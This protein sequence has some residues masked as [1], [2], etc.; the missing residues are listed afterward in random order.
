MVSAPGGFT[1][2]G[3]SSPI[4]VS[5][6][7][8][9]TAYTFTVTATNVVGTSTASSA[10]NSVTPKAVP[11]APTGVSAAA[12]NGQAE[13]SFTAPSND[14]GS[15]ITGYTVTSSPGGFTGTGSVS[16]ITVSGL[17][18]GTTYTFTVTATNAE[19]TSIASSASSGV[20]P[21]TLPDAP[22]A[23][24]AT[25]GDTE[26]TI[27]FTAPT[28]NGGS[29]IT[30]Y[31]VT[32]S[33]GGLTGT[34]SSSPITVTGLTNGT[35]YTF[36]V[37]ATNTAGVSAASE[38]SNS[39]TPK[40][41][42]IA[43][44]ATISDVATS[45]FAISLDQDI[46]DISP[47]SFILKD[48]NEE[49]VPV[50]MVTSDTVATYNVWTRLAEGAT[51]SLSLAEEGY[52][53]SN[54]VELTVP[55]VE[56]TEI[57]A[58]IDWVSH[59]AFQ[60]T[61]ATDIGHLYSNE[62]I[63]KNE[64]GV[65]VVVSGVTKKVDGFTYIVQAALTGDQTYAYQI[66]T[67]DNKAASGS[68]YAANIMTISTQATS[69]TTSGFTV[70]LSAPLTG[71]TKA[72]FALTDLSSNTNIDIS[73]VTTGNQGGSYQISTSI[74]SGKTYALTI[75][76]E[77]YTV[78]DTNIMIPTLVNV[79]AFAIWGAG[80]AYAG[81]SPSVPGLDISNFKITNENGDDIPLTDAYFDSTPGRGFYLLT[82]PRTNGLIYTLK[83][84]KPGYD[85]GADKS[86]NSGN[87][88]INNIFNASKTGFTLNLT[89]VRTI[90]TADFV[91]KNAAGTV[92]PITS[93][94]MRDSGANY[95][96]S[97][98]MPSGNYTI[99][100]TS[101]PGKT[102]PLIR[103]PIE[104]ALTVDQVEKSSFTVHLSSPFPGLKNTD[105]Y[106]RTGGGYRNPTS[107]STTDNGLTYQVAIA[108]GLPAATYSVKFEGRISSTSEDFNSGAGA[109]IVIPEDVDVKNAVLSNVTKNG[110]SIQFSHAVPGL[111]PQHLKLTDSS[112]VEL[113]N[114][115]LA[116]SDG[117][118]NYTVSAALENG[119]DYRAV[120]QKDY[121]AFDASNEI[122]VNYWIEAAV[123]EVTSNG[124]R[125]ALN[126]ALPNLDGSNII[127]KDAAGNEIYEALATTDNGASYTANVGNVDY[128]GWGKS[129]T[130]SLDKAG[131]SLTPINLTTPFVVTVTSFSA[132]QVAVS[133]NSP[134]PGL[135]ASK[136]K[137]IN[138]AGQSVPISAVNSTDGG[139]T[140]AIEA[141]MPAGKAYWITY[142]PG[143]EY[144]VYDPVRIAVA[145]T[146]T[147]LV[148]HSTLKGFMIQF[149]EEI[150]GL[151]AKDLA[152]RNQSGVKLPFDQ[153]TLTKVDGMATYEVAYN[154]VIPETYTVEL[155]ADPYGTYQDKYAMAALSYVIP[156]PVKIS[157][158]SATNNRMVL[159][160]NQSLHLV[161]S[162]FALTDSEGQEVDFTVSETADSVYEF[163]TTA[164]EPT[165]YLLTVKYPGYDFGSALT[166]A[167]HIQA[168]TFMFNQTQKGMTIR[169]TP[170]IPDMEISHFT[171]TDELGDPVDIDAVTTTDFGKS[172]RV[173]AAL[174]SGH[175]YTVTMARPNYTFAPIA[176]FSLIANGA[177]INNVGKN[178]FK[179]NLF[180]THTFGYVDIRVLNEDGEKQA[181]QGLSS[182]DSG[183]TYD[184][185]LPLAPGV[186][187]TVQV[188][189]LNITSASQGNDYGED[190]P[191][192]VLA[193]TPSF[194]GIVDHKIIMKLVPAL[195]DLR[196]S[197][198]KLSA[199][200]DEI[201]IVDAVTEDGGATYA[202]TATFREGNVYRIIPSKDGYDFGDKMALPVPYTVLQTVFDIGAKEVKLALNPPLAGLDASHFI[203]KDSSGNR[204]TYLS[205]STDDFGATYTIAADF[206][207]GETYSI[208]LQ[209]SGY[210]FGLDSS[211][212]IPATIV[213]TILSI[214]TS[215]V[216]VGFKPAVT[217]MTAA[218]FSL[219]NGVAIDSVATTDGGATYTVSASLSE[220][221]TYSL[222]LARSGY[223]FD[224][225]APS[226]HVDVPTAATASDYI[227]SG[228][229]L[230]V[231]PALP[232]LV[233]A[234]LTL[235]DEQGNSV[236]ISSISSSDGGA[237]YTV[238]AAL[239]LGRTYS[240][241]IAKAGY[242]FG[243]SSAFLVPIPVAKSVE[244]ISEHGLVL[245]LSPAVAQ[246]TLNELSLRDSSGAYVAIHS[247]TTADNGASYK[248]EAALN[249]D[250]SYELDAGKAGYSFGA[251][252]SV[253]VSETIEMSIGS[254]EDTYFVVKF[255][256]PVPR[257]NGNY[258]QVHDDAGNT[259]SFPNPNDVFDQSGASFTGSSFEVKLHLNAGT[260]YTLEIN[261]PEHPFGAP[262]EVIKPIAV[263]PTVTKPMWNSFLLTLGISTLDLS[264]ADI[265]LFTSDGEEVTGLLL[266]P[267]DSAG[268]YTIRGNIAE[269]N[270]YTLKLH[271][272]GYD[273]GGDISFHVPI[274]VKVLISNQDTNGF[275]ITLSPSV[276]DLAVSLKLNG[277]SVNVTS[278]VT[279][280]E[281]YTY[282]VRTDLGANTIHQLALSK[283]GYDFGDPQSVSNAATLPVI[284][285]AVT[286][287]IGS[288]IYLNF[289][290]AF[291]SL[292][293]TAIFSV[294]SNNSWLH[295]ISARLN[296]TDK[297]QIIITL[298]PYTLLGPAD[299][300]SV[301]Y[302]GKNTAK[303]VNGTYLAAFADV[304]VR[305]GA[306]ALGYATTQAR[307]DGVKPA[308]KLKDEFHLNALDAGTTM[309]LAGF[310]A[311]NYGRSIANVYG[312]DSAGMAQ[313]LFDM[314]ADGL[315][316][317]K[318]Q[319]RQIGPENLANLIHAGY[320]PVQFIPALRALNYQSNMIAEALQQAD[321][322]YYDITSIL[323]NSLLDPAGKTVVTLRSIRVGLSEIVS[324]IG[325]VY[326]ME[327]GEVYQALKTGGISVSDAIAAL[328][329]NQGGSPNAV[330]A[331]KL[332]SQAG[333][334]A[335][336]IGAVVKGK[337]FFETT[338][339]LIQALKDADLNE[340]NIYAAASR[341]VSRKDAA[342]AMLNKGIPFGSILTAVKAAGDSDGALTIAHAFKLTGLGALELAA[343]LQ[344]NGYSVQEA[345]DG[346]LTAGFGLTELALVLKRSY[347][348]D[349][350]TAYGILAGKY[351][352]SYVGSTP[353]TIFKAMVG[354]GYESSPLA[355]YYLDHVRN[356][357]LL[358]VLQ[359]L[360]N[361]GLST[362]EALLIVHD[363]ARAD[364]YPLTIDRAFEVFVDNRTF[365]S[366]DEVL[367][368]VLY[369]FSNDESVTLD[370]QT[371]GL[372]F[373]KIFVHGWPSG[374]YERGM[375]LRNRM[376]MT[377]Q[378]WM[379]L[380][381]SDSRVIGTVLPWKILR[382][383]MMLFGDSTVTIQDAVNA[384][385]SSDKFTLDEV[386][387]GVDGYL[388]DT[389]NVQG[390]MA[391]LKNTGL[392]MQSILAAI[393]SKS[394]Y[395][396]NWISQFKRYGLTA[397]DV[398]AYYSGKGK[399]LSEIVD[400]LSPYS[401]NEIVLVLRADYGK[402][403]SEVM[404]LLAG[405]NLREVS[406]A[407]SYIYREATMDVAVKL[408]KVQGYNAAEVG[409]YLTNHGVSNQG[410]AN[411]GVY[412]N[413]LA[414]AGFT[415]SEVTKVV[416]A[417]NGGV[418]QLPAALSALKSRYG[419]DQTGLAVILQGASVT[420]AT[421]AVEFMATHAYTLQ[422]MVLG[423]KTVY[424]LTAGETTALLNK[425]FAGVS[426]A[427][428][429]KTILNQV[430]LGY[431]STEESTI[432]EVL[433]G[434]HIS[435]PRAAIVK[436]RE[437]GYDKIDLQLNLTTVVKLLKN[438][439]GLEAAEAT[440]LLFEDAKY[441]SI[442]ISAAVNAVYRSTDEVGIASALLISAGITDTR[443]AVLYLNGR[444]VGI[445]LIA[446]V[447]REVYQVDST[448]A[449]EQLNYGL[450][451]TQERIFLALQE[452]YGVDPMFGYLS[453]LMRKGATAY[454]LANVLDKMNRT[455]GDAGRNFL[456]D[457]LKSLGYTKE[458]IMYEI[459]T[460][461]KSYTS[462]DEMAQ[463]FIRSGYKDALSI[464]AQLVGHYNRN[465]GFNPV[466]IE[467]AA[468]PNATSGSL[469]TAL[470]MGG[471]TAEATVGGL[472]GNNRFD[473]SAAALLKEFGFGAIRS[474][475][476]LHS[477]G[478]STANKISWLKQWGFPLTDYLRTLGN[479]DGATVSLLRSNGY[480]AVEI[481][482]AL[483]KANVSD[484]SIIRALDE[485]GFSELGTLVDAYYQSGVQLDWVIRNIYG[486][487][488]NGINPR[489]SIVAI[490][491]ALYSAN[492][493]LSVLQLTGLINFANNNNYNQTYLALNEI[494][495]A[496]Q[497]QF[498]SE[499]SP[500]EL[501]ILKDFIEPIVSLS[502]LRSAGL[503]AHQAATVLRDGAEMTDW[504]NAMLIM[505][506]AGYDEDMIAALFDV[507]RAA[508]GF[509]II[510]SMAGTQITKVFDKWKIVY[511]F[512]K[513]I[514]EMIIQANR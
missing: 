235:L 117:G 85:F 380:A 231:S 289:D 26:A 242:R 318:A 178:G 20:T 280:D 207:G 401:V 260:F 268:T 355:K 454:E 368:A 350:G 468:W 439:Y 121:F 16:P 72:N 84:T 114:V 200:A 316:A 430:A 349:M 11:G 226:F 43:V 433:A 487:G 123:K 443:A 182:P 65:R 312:L 161:Q 485:G 258:L 271:R 165:V 383:T 365:F 256:R 345:V 204:L 348:L 194:E 396:S 130:V 95:D 290:K 486:Y 39:V 31:T 50:D 151:R 326:G 97:A 143:L 432:L 467:I 497:D 329:Q 19:G 512:T 347:A 358:F 27:T 313:L 120:F 150:A 388:G 248:L 51:Y 17:T 214:G 292:A 366:T 314:G 198:F 112:N 508:I 5:G 30:G 78:A 142:T 285:S 498:R 104:L 259:Y 80:Q 429:L 503:T 395:G 32:S 118:W 501:L 250:E 110:F 466:A 300:V 436:M 228:L 426:S 414:T 46:A 317:L 320:D 154:L 458:S 18:Y 245:K 70:S 447:L 98:T 162:N 372:G 166:I 500:A 360:K 116:T 64:E 49:T 273:F 394:V 323:R 483:Y 277:Q 92:I 96:F 330:L 101:L 222:S 215:G 413:Y 455:L 40:V 362:S 81:L 452:A 399:T 418:L 86:I 145:K 425:R 346:V 398:A 262:I 191:L 385:S 190:I 133:F 422:Q 137:I 465:E 291:T 209:K 146:V 513:K 138:E 218:E 148:T 480:T 509:E 284:I 514:A 364:G 477:A 463:Y 375:Q 409:T 249:P 469:A 244:F 353:S 444:N 374:F 264:L 63:L 168:S 224:P 206:I 227:S 481:A 236:A 91:L 179:L 489:W 421:E 111:L 293:N 185:E 172:Y 42:D 263:A 8:N 332:L 24:I 208:A 219:S 338:E 126:P 440:R 257:F 237:N 28:S 294:K 298:D 29:A 488:Y 392:P 203:F 187:Y 181:I 199:L 367:A 495:T 155:A 174:S 189:N 281:G 56:K 68:L 156:I 400:L 238:N 363:I 128:L 164:T 417:N 41:P 283:T 254:I 177:F 310:A 434:L 37:T 255:S 499:S 390:I 58:T 60:L 448:T 456:I 102:F 305:I 333:Y 340:D 113:T 74:S 192:Q 308:R 243:V 328:A 471:F 93:V 337:Y 7:S 376:G 201:P 75:T 55:V 321:V 79:A 83:I 73:S 435:S 331:I 287:E 167:T 502:T 202:L 48:N 4:T 22:T 386:V 216:V 442:L 382:D 322:S 437:L 54:H 379:E 213:P 175:E 3:L 69:L 384:M 57:P 10:S 307:Y 15:A 412:I 122:H 359:E 378:Q 253:T 327:P 225:G 173:S 266:D 270:S 474:S 38:P 247:F 82:F 476:I 357:D 296:E 47:L 496:E 438:G 13:V 406:E 246:L 309:M 144:V 493:T 403:S 186:A 408:L 275:T 423:L 52:A 288:L 169:F 115:T 125:L 124:F 451:Y 171:I 276:L 341:S 251:A 491:K 184:V 393:E 149:S 410:E 109:T 279:S 230:K 373:Y 223:V 229:K 265:S 129:Y 404:P 334:S 370:V 170:A 461:Y 76:A 241:A 234:D 274:A 193:V 453:S 9:G 302:A 127:I 361:T 35:A 195:P 135:T 303:A 183:L 233:E 33:P 431:S 397:N 470:R 89:P 301:A 475:E 88:E 100:V 53:F 132:T 147:A 492:N 272:K 351:R 196:A 420:T 472:L 44:S 356:R 139:L 506:V 319:N 484:I 23:V 107:I 511:K 478:Y 387:S 14:G 90:N 306:T 77:G 220:G 450:G 163:T 134:N 299:T 66:V 176:A 1:G 427:F 34:G 343:A 402:T 416:L 507:Y 140:Y 45:G 141:S 12:G 211:A 424:N 136:F 282:Q 510:M 94:T 369:A 411:L 504:M 25:A 460:R 221:T 153:Y 297:T 459:L 36:T 240:L 295:G 59:T 415:Q 278:A 449:Y 261:D 232:G 131:Y 479:L 446:R 71:L 494:A 344:S 103:V 324:L 342:I 158:L 377:M 371:V 6:L 152:I 464:A 482:K 304:P 239:T 106:I 381:K 197:N 339:A 311:N 188:E 180:K 352:Y 105:L 457:T 61:F 160:M 99:A 267:G 473:D 157:V 445:D 505:L 269:G 315:T 210:N 428:T 325:S 87:F 490:A 391:L 407:V 389:R 286:N 67:A 335:K 462:N 212:A 405:R 354:A 2:T 62:I 336:E 441:S 119:K 21:I 419:G 217:G 205:V 159:S 108:G 252:T